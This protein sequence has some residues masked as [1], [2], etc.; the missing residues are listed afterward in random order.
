MSFATVNLRD[1]V[2]TGSSS[3]DQEE[4]SLLLPEKLEVFHNRPSLAAE[5]MP[6]GTCLVEEMFCSANQ[7]PGGKSNVFGI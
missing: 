5:V 7:E 3:G 4:E 1:K 6:D 2:S